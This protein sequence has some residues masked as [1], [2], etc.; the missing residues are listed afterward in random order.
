MNFF[1]LAAKKLKHVLHEEKQNGRKR[2]LIQMFPEKPEGYLHLSFHGIHTDLQG[3]GD[4]LIFHIVKS[5]HQKYFP[6]LVR[7]AIYHTI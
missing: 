1:C 3:V 6:A 7:Q 2:I 4:L 5:C